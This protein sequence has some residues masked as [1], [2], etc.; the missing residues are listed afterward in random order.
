MSCVE[1]LLLSPAYWH[2]L[3]RR[4]HALLDRQP[5]LLRAVHALPTD[6]D[7]WH[8]FRATEVDKNAGRFIVFLVWL[9]R[10]SD[11]YRHYRRLIL[12]HPDSCVPSLLRLAVVP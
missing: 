12:H 7:P 6:E 1:A 9:S 10:R 3:C 8:V 11:A 4:C 2:A 5:A